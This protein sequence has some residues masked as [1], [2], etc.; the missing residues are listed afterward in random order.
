[1]EKAE[2]YGN[3]AAAGQ[4]GGRRAPATARR[5]AS[6]GGGRTGGAGVSRSG[7]YAG[8]SPDCLCIWIGRRDLDNRMPCTKGMGAL[9]AGTT[10]SMHGK[11]N[12]IRVAGE[13]HFRSWLVYPHDGPR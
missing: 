6:S 9:Q 4:G 3:G 13:C 1:V 12:R 10:F 8:K 7:K 5:G 2:F 11:I